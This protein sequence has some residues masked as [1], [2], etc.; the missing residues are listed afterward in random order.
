M[1]DIFKSNSLPIINKCIT[2]DLKPKPLSGGPYDIGTY[3]KG[4]PLLEKYDIVSELGRGKFGVVSLCTNKKTGEKMACKTFTKP[5]EEDEMVTIRREIAI[6]YHLANNK[7]VVT[8][9]DVHEDENSVNLIMD[10]CE[11]GVLYKQLLPGGK[12]ECPLDEPTA[13]KMFVNM[14]NITNS[15]HDL[16]VCH[17][18][19]KPDNFLLAKK[20]FSEYDIKISDFG[21]SVFYTQNPLSTCVGSPFYVAPE[22]LKRSYSIEVDIW[23]MGVILY[24]QLGGTFP[25]YGSTPSEIFDNVK[26]AEPNIN[27]SDWDNVSPEAKDLVKCLLN[28]DPVKRITG[29]EAFKH[30]WILKHVPNTKQTNITT[31]VPMRV[32]INEFTRSIRNAYVNLIHEQIKK[33]SK[34][35]NCKELVRALSIVNRAIVYHGSTSSTTYFKKKRGT[36][37]NITGDFTVSMIRT[38]NKMY[39][40]DIIEFAYQNGYNRIGRWFETLV[41]DSTESV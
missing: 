29:K 11:G 13:A 1:R 22:V 18:D 26:F 32:F 30:P 16:G 28:K 35:I 6:L 39:D 20:P 2:E 15:I 5:I 8:L 3:L 33:P 12:F 23:S 40:I 37:E 4:I 19:I 14:L 25:F 24:I 9:R 36:I 38:L 34:I 41:N 27:S 31:T 10:L 7:D 17:R 21:L